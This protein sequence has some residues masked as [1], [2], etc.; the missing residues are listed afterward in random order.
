MKVSAPVLG[1]YQ[2]PSAPEYTYCHHNAIRGL[3]RTPPISVFTKDDNIPS[4]NR[5]LPN[6]HQSYQNWPTEKEKQKNKK[7]Q[8]TGLPSLQELSY[9]N[10]NQL[11]RNKMFKTKNSM[12]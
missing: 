12:K 8:R 11:M 1:P 10:P 6:P 7:P 5:A 3:T 2:N 4:N 9:H